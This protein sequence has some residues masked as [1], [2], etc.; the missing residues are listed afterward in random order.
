MEF[1]LWHSGLGIRHCLCDSVGLIPS[2]VQWVK[3]PVLAQ[4]WCR[5]QLWLRF[6]SLAQE[7]PCAV[8]L[9]KKGKMIYAD[10]YPEFKTKH[11]ILDHIP[12]NNDHG[13]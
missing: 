6:K 10:G 2:L 4:L 9:A 8:G 13:F 7:I 5:S 1:P 3:D 11:F 12:G